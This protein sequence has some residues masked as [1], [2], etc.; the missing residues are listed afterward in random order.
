MP[1]VGDGGCLGCRGSVAQVVSQGQGEEER[2]NKRSTLILMRCA[3]SHS[4]SAQLGA[5]SWCLHFLS[6]HL[7]CH[8]LKRI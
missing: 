3:K 7:G 6:M 8:R 4:A 1:C 5:Q 2:R